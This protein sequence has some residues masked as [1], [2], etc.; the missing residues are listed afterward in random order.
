[1]LG[2]NLIHVSKRGHWNSRRMHG[3]CIDVSVNYISTNQRIDMVKVKVT[4]L[5]G[6]H[7]QAQSS[8]LQT[9][10]STF[11]GHWAFYCPYPSRSNAAWSALLKGTTSSRT[12]RVLNPGLD[13][14]PNPESCTLTL[15]QLWVNIISKMT[16]CFRHPW[17]SRHNNISVHTNKHR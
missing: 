10:T 2:L 17:H 1:M 4:S 8:A 13:L 14:D 5:F 6:V 12:G 3:T 15:D 16:L 7:I 9:L 11:P